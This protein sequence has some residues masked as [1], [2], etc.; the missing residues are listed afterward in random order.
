M[1]E[2]GCDLKASG[3]YENTLIFAIQSG[4]FQAFQYLSTGT[5]SARKLYV[6]VNPPLPG[7]YV[8]T[9]ECII[10]TALVGVG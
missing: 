4:N 8:V 2:R 6:I 10:H 9:H 5:S 3:D 7:L 1:E